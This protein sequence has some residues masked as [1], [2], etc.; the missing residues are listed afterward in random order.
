MRQQLLQFGEPAP[1]FAAATTANR[2]F[3]FDTVGGR[4]VLLMFFQSAARPDSSRILADLWQQRARFDDEHVTFFG[5][6]TDPLDQQLARVQEQLPGIRTFWDF[7]SAVSQMF[8]A[9]QTD[10]A[11]GTPRYVCHTVLLDPRLRAMAAIPF[12]E[13]ET[14]VAR[15]LRLI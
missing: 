15:L 5:I 4:Y 9:A 7:D 10:A 2:S 1:W 8:G 6:S 13:P 14:Y 3:Q 11:T 12:A